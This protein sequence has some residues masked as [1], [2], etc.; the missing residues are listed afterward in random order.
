MVGSLKVTPILKRPSVFSSLIWDIMWTFGLDSTP[1]FVPFFAIKVF[2]VFPP[3]VMTFVTNKTFPEEEIPAAPQLGSALILRRQKVHES[4]LIA[5]R[6][7]E[8]TDK[9]LFASLGPTEDGLKQL[10][11]RFRYRRIYRRFHSQGSSPESTRHGLA[12]ELMQK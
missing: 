2:S 6:V 8:I 5:F 9:E 12:P 1:H 11:G 7:M 10:Q 4:A 3:W